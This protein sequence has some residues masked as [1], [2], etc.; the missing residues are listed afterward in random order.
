MDR[1]LPLP[2]LLALALLP[3]ATAATAPAPSPAF[4]AA[5]APRFDAYPGDPSLKNVDNAGEPAIGIP[6]NTDHA[7]FQAFSSTYRVSF[8]DQHLEAGRP[9]A[10][11]QDA[12][13]AFTPINVDPMLHADHVSNRVWAGG[14]A[15]ACSLM[16]MSDNDGFTWVPAGN[17]C[18][19]AQFDHQSI[20]S[21]P[22]A[23]SAAPR[24]A[25]YGRATYYCSQ[26]Q[27]GTAVGST[28][29]TACTTSL[30]GGL[31][32][33]PFTEVLGGCGG[34]HGHI[35]VS[36][37]TGTATVPDASC[38]TGEG[39]AVPGG[40]ITAGPEQMGFGYTTDNGVTWNSRSIPGSVSSPGG[41]DP[42]LDF[43]RKSGWLY[44]AQ[45]D[46]QGIHVAMSKDEGKAWETLGGA[47]DGAEPALWLNLS[48]A[49]HDPRTGSPIRFATFANTLAGDDG[50][51]AV[52]FLG[53]TN[54]TAQHPFDDCSKISDG[55]L[56][57][58]Y[59]AQTFDAGQK[60]TVSRLWE[61]P[62]QVGAI[63]DGGGGVPCRN[64]LDFAG[65]DMDSHGRLH[66]ALADG[67]T[68]KCAQK[69]F[70]WVD[71]KGPAP[72][73][74]DS[75]TQ[76]ATILRQTTGL[77]LF[78]KDDGMGS[79]LPNPR[80]GTASATKGTPAADLA[81]VLAALALGVGLV[82]RRRA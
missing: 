59:L 68:G 62:V 19:F 64:L 58:Y 75:R 26:L 12:S 13:P 3:L 52:A 77:G 5:G 36:E 76:Y 48:A 18:N 4:G 37:V 29:G 6:W 72:V 71:G 25:V 35:R 44:Y 33:L 47:T 16:G 42:S 60:W 8:D 51:A 9:V 28:P 66:I 38:H 24:G 79:G 2:L 61:D 54:A 20:G 81:P 45:A 39:S 43:S 73:G 49:Y 41:F 17:M 78:A 7:F 11:W 80:T 46:Q 50:R 14:L 32:W 30:D 57:H 63:W 67:C 34:L 1:L 69:Y 10:L 27:L 65:M 53:S 22:W 31:T 70:D 15:G 56:W 40:V 55:V 82:R 74:A 23:G 21:G